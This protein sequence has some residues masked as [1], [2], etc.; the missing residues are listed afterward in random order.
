[1][2]SLVR[3]GTVREMIIV[4]P[5]GRNV[6][7]G[8]FYTN[9]E[10]TGNWDDFIARELVAY[11][12]AKYRTVA[13]PE[14]R[15]LAGHSM[16]GYGTY[17]VG[18]R[19]AG[20]VY[21]A[22]Y[23]MSGCCTQVSRTPS[24]PE[25]WTMLAN[26]RST[27]DVAK[28]Q[29]FPKVYLAMTAAFS[30]NAAGPMFLTLPYSMRDGESLQVVDSVYAKWVAHAP[31]DMVPAYATG[32]RKLRG[33]MFDVGTSDALVTVASQAAMDSAFTRAGVRHTFETY[34]G[35][36]SNRIAAR[37]ATSVLP[38]FSKTLDFGGSAP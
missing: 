32:L 20:D 22:L 8:S 25:V 34:D 30:P 24:R 1:M 10:S 37:L 14:S 13:R 11:I 19:H 21:G 38:F 5:N 27:A 31:L 4:M 17:A 33:L 23:A 18:M 9:S 26:V 36:H 29:F 6:F 3:N 28:L 12:D 15:G 16:G 35:D 7:D 2:D